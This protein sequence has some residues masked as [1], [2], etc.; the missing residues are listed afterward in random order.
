MAVM[1]EGQVAQLGT[2]GEVYEYP[3][4]RFVAD[5]IGDVNLLEARVVEAGRESVRAHAAEAGCDVLAD[6][7]AA[8]VVPG[9]AVWVAV[10]PEKLAVSKEPPPAETSANY[11]AGVVWD[12]GYL[13][14][15]S[16]Y[17]V[18][19]DGGAV[20]RATQANRRRLVERPITW[21]DRV[22]LSWAPDAS[23]VLKA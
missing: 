5:F 19:T 10:R 11:V 14:D 16:I 23:V 20:L 4:T 1:S 22:W 9:Q 6:R 17:H 15:V 3:A 7:A 21:E 18:R 2:P 12:I 13:G 8:G